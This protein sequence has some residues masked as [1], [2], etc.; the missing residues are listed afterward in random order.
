[1]MAILTGVRGY[2]IVV[3]ICIYLIIRDIEHFSYT[4]WPYVWLLWRNF[5]LGLLPIF[6]LGCLVFFVC[7]LSCMSYL[8]ILEIR[9]LSGASFAKI[10][11][12]SMDCPFCGIFGFRIRVMVAS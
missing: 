8:Y 1:M 4:C 2:L 12:S 5:Y 6:Q 7:L 3:L 11:S 10:F 9:P